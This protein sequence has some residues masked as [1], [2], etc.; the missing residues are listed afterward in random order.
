MIKNKDRLLDL[1]SYDLIDTLP[2]SIYD[3]ITQLAAAICSSPISLIS[4]ITDEKQFFKSHY[5]LE[6]NETPL[7]D[8]FCKY[9]VEEDIEL[10]IV[11]D[12]R[13]DERFI[14]NGFVSGAPYIS[15]YAGVRLTSPKG[16]P[17]GALCVIDDKPKKIR[18]SE[19]DALKIL[20]KQIVQSFELRKATKEIAKKNEAL[21]N[22]MRYSLDIICTIDKN[23]CFSEMNAASKTVWGYDPN[24]LIS[25]KYL[26]I[27]HVDDVVA[28]KKWADSLFSNKVMNHF[29]NRCLHKEG[30]SVTMLWSANYHEKDGILY[31]VAKNITATK[32]ANERI[33]QSE[34]RFK[35]LVQEGSDLIAILDAE[36]NYIYVSPST[37]SVL[38]T[39]PDEYIDTNAFD[40]IHPDD[41]PSVYAQFEKIRK[42]AQVLIEP[43][44]FKNKK[45]EWRWLETIVTNQMNEPSIKGLVANSRDITDRKMYLSAIEEQNEKLKDIA[46]KQ[47]HVV[48]A[49]VARLMGLI[50]L[51]R[52]E[53]LNRKEKELILNSIMSSA[54]EI[55][56]VIKDIV[57]KTT[58][59]IPKQ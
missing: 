27:V 30:F 40:Y 53:K 9:V 39:N 14:E 6:I 10:M 32:E 41:L 42:H 28:T 48:R 5:G 33:Q 17:L 37:L 22:I 43:F 50:N 45:G 55:D 47:S 19:I 23:G 2:E 25:E 58:Y 36:A 34:Q 31:C 56:S 18:Q 35:T 11:E 15:F 20:A 54:E 57:D 26:D 38:Q 12:A 52:E 1:E 4:L 24:E 7:E 8:S 59:S 46:W 51:I 49:P 16:L 29:E 13:K 3:D 44:R 21:E